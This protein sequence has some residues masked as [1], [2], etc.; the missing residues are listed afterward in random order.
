MR[1]KRLPLEKLE[2]LSEWVSDKLVEYIY[3]AL[4]DEVDELS[5]NVDLNEEWPYTLQVEVY[6]KTKT[7]H[8]GLNYVLDKVLDKTFSEFQKK[9]EEEGF[10]PAG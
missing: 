3:D 5:I 10:K 9:I 2:H 4:D 1:V 7:R 6:V 8:E